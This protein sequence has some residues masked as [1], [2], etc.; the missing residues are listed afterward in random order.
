MNK[1]AAAAIHP[2]VYL[3]T[4]VI[5]KL[6]ISISALA[7][8]LQMNRGSLSD[9][10]NGKQG[11]GDQLAIRLEMAGIGSAD[12]WRVMQ[13]RYDLQLARAQPQPKIARLIARE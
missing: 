9:T 4:E 3:R 10:L 11:I 12:D 8:H 6:E 5:D 13:T 7:E 2:G 1:K